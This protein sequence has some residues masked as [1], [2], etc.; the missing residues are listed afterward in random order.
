MA[1]HLLRR[2]STPAGP[3]FSWVWS[4]RLDQRLAPEW[5]PGRFRP[6]PN[7]RAER[8]HHTL[9]VGWA[10]A[11]CYPS[12]AKLGSEIRAPFPTWSI[13]EITRLG[14]TLRK[15]RPA[16]LAYFDTAEVSNGATEAINSVIMTRHCVA[17]GFRDLDNYRFR[18][19]LTAAGTGHGERDLPIPFLKG[20]VLRRHSSLRQL[21]QLSLRGDRVSTIR[22]RCPDPRP[23]EPEVPTRGHPSPKSP[24]EARHKHKKEHL[25]SARRKRT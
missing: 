10:N 17:C 20:C 25:S 4:P 12:E 3:G 16:I 24:P 21:I 6:Q 22:A 7:D 9:A 1:D 15:W 2:S 13:L 14:Y 23:S 11:R 5:P 8:F 18:A 19:P